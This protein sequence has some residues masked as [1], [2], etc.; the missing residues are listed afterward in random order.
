MPERDRKELYEDVLFELEKKEKEE[1]KNLRR[2]NIKVLKDILESMPKVTYK[3]RWSEA[4]KLLFKDP[5]F[6]QDTELQ[7]MDKEDALIV[8]EDHI[9]T[10]EKEHSEDMDKRKR[11][12]RRQE[13]KNRDFFLCLLDELREQGK[14]NS[15]SLWVELYSVISADERF[16]A[17]LYQAG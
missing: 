16:N 9:K 1:T 14:L 15:M 11:W 17:M 5:H 4:Q 13:R 12:Q 3:T 6:T 10:L 7:N 8:F 2:R